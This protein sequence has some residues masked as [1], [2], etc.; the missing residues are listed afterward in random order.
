MRYAN[1]EDHILSKSD[2]LKSNEKDSPTGQEGITEPSGI[3]TL[4]STNC[5][6]I[7]PSSSKYAATS[8][9]RALDSKTASGYLSEAPSS[10]QWKSLLV[11]SCI[12]DK[13]PNYSTSS[14]GNIMLAAWNAYDTSKCA[15]SK[16]EQE[17]TTDW[18]GLTPIGP[19][20]VCIGVDST[21]G[22]LRP[23]LPNIHSRLCA[24]DEVKYSSSSNQIVNNF[25]TVSHGFNSLGIGRNAL[26]KGK[27]SA[28]RKQNG[29]YLAQ[30]TLRPF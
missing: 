22:Q 17:S 10:Q 2:L 12:P 27:S 5:R 11:G 24:G 3:C 21:T 1:D 20:W 7:A 9:R 30:S 23:P 15:A 25:V 28:H 18:F 19:L 6:A 29:K 14:R 8:A 16:S 26:C 13:R 4:R